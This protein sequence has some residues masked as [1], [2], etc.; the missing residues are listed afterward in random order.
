VLLAGEIAHRDGILQVD[1]DWNAVGF[2]R[3][4]NPAYLANANSGAPQYIFVTNAGPV[5]SLP[6]GIVT[7]SAG[8]TANKL[9]GL[10]FAQGGAVRQ[11][12]FGDLTF[13][14]VSG[15][16]VPLRTRGGDRL[17]ND[18]GRNIGLEPRDD[19]QGVFGR[20]SYEITDGV[21]LFAEAAYNRQEVLF[22]AGPNLQTGIMQP[23]ARRRRCQP[24][25]TLSCSTRWAL[26]SCRASPA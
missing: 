19:R 13:P 25:A 10:Y 3:F 26:H 8:G 23:A 4:E 7:N 9:R 5:N 11:F 14:A 15:G 6:G 16:A 24:P 18:S 17:L 1:R 2:L 20:I 22:N 21:E 12:V